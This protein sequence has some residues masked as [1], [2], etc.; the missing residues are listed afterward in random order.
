MLYAIRNPNI[1]NARNM[2]LLEQAKESVRKQSDM[3]IRNLN[4][5]DTLSA[6][7]EIQKILATIPDKP[8]LISQ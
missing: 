3:A 7:L 6:R 8:I 1:T 2:V 5:G 4:V